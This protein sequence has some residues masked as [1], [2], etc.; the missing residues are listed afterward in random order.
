MYLSYE[1]T[2]EIERLEARIQSKQNQIYKLERE[3]EQHSYPIVTGTGGVYRGGSVAASIKEE[4][5]RVKEEKARLE[6]QL[7]SIYGRIAEDRRRIN[8]GSREEEISARAREERNEKLKKFQNAEIR[9][10]NSSFFY[11]LTHF[12]TRPN[13]IYDQLDNMDNDEINSLYKRW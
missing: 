6:E 3:A 9:W 2:R 4:I 10:E 12:K 11:K 7:R 13:K 5:K 1:E 8:S